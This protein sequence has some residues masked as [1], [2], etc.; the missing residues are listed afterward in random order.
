[1]GNTIALIAS[2]DTKSA[3]ILFAKEL[4][5]K[6]GMKA[7]LIDIS[8]RNPRLDLADLASPEILKSKDVKWEDFDT[9]DRAARIELLA[10]SLAAVIPRYYQNGS[11]NGILSIGGGQNARMAAGAMKNLPYGV[12]KIIVAPLISGKRELEQYVFDRDIMVM[13]SV[14]DFSGLNSMTKMIISNAVGAITGMTEAFKPYEKTAGKKTVGI[15]LLGITSRG[16]TAAIEALEAKG[17]ETMGFH[18]NGTGGRCFENLIWDGVIDAALDM[19]LHELTCE[20]FGGYCTGANNRLSAAGEKGIP[21]VFVPGG[22]DVIDYYVAEIIPPRFDERQKI[23]HNAHVCHTKIF[24]EEAQVLGKVIADR[25]NAAKGPVAV[26]LPQKGFCEAGAPGGKLCNPET[27]KVLM[28]SLKQNLDPRINVKT[29]DANVNDPEC[30]L[31]CA[32][33]ILEL[34]QQS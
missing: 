15:S 25:L 21:L 5:E 29:V 14:A 18:A 19:N 27:D 20:H 11:F 17:L 31:M 12:P 26:I 34:M 2:L 28:D 10:E 30:A 13:H 7:F 22:V 4:V 1:M 32:D 33:L 23:Y 9:K 3:E 6:R 16:A 8:A 24:K